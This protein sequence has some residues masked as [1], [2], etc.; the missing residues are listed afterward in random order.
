MERYNAI[1]GDVGPWGK[2]LASCF[3]DLGL[4]ALRFVALKPL[5]QISY[6]VVLLTLKA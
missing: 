1:G 6:F 5:R 2:R 3:A 4:R